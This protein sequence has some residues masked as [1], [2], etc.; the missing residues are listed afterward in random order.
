MIPKLKNLIKDLVAYFFII[1]TKVDKNK[2]VCSNFD[3]KGFGCNPKYIALELVKNGFEVVWLTNNLESDI[4]KNIRV[5][6]KR[7]IKAIYELETAKVIVTNV[8]SGP[9]FI[10][11]KKQY[12]IQTWHGSYSAK[13]SEKAVFK[14]DH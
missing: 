13:P 1:F 4:P 14:I 6:K 7:S 11:R 3:G 10:K 9:R 5:V 8:T 12:L 2:V